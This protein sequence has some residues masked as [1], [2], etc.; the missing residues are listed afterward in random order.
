MEDD[1]AFSH[2]DEYKQMEEEL[3]TL[4]EEMEGKQRMHKTLVDQLKEDQGHRKALQNDLINLKGKI[5]VFCRI[6]P[7]DLGKKNQQRCI[8]TMK[9]NDEN[10]R[11]TDTQ[12]DLKDVSGA[13]KKFEF[14]KVFD[15]ESTQEQV[16]EEL[17]ALVT[18]TL[19]GNNVC[20]FAYGQTGSGK[21]H[22]MEGSDNTVEGMGMIP[23]TITALCKDI[24]ERSDGDYQIQMSVV[25]LYN[26]RFDDL[27]AGKPDLGRGTGLALQTTGPQAPCVASLRKIP[28]ESFSSI[29]QI[30]ETAK[31]NRKTAETKGNKTSSRSHLILTL[32][33]T[34]T[35]KDGKVKTSKLHMVDL[36]GSEAPQQGKVLGKEDPLFK[37]GIAINQSL[38]V[39]GR[40]LRA[41]KA[42]KAHDVPPYNEHPLTQ[43]LKDSFG[44][45][46]SKTLMIVHVSPLSIDYGSS[47]AA[48]ELGAREI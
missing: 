41:A 27:L 39:L 37:E 32:Y 48:I 45:K 28:V 33:V 5:R 40:V 19:D 29:S 43:L 14:D 34:M 36:A 10:H 4:T 8:F 47:K 46:Q 13:D 18:S 11:L 12:V 1:D 2:S 24:Q 6:R 9:D 3:R 31:E 25:Q 21:T 42:A 38:V 30:W 20:V 15:E 23:R 35:P 44:D 17:Q 7:P 22:T 26:K 16:F